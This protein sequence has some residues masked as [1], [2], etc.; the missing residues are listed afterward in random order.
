MLRTFRTSEQYVK[1]GSRPAFSVLGVTDQSA[2]S[3][4]TRLQLSRRVS[5]HVQNSATDRKFRFFSV[6][7]VIVARRALRSLLRSDSTPLTAS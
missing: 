7:R 3:D 6:V 4:A 2:R 5:E 1:T